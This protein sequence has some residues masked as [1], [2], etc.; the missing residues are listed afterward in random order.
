MEVIVVNKKYKSTIFSYIGEL[1][2]LG[3]FFFDLLS[4]RLPIT[5]INWIIF[6]IGSTIILSGML[7]SIIIIY[8][9]SHNQN[10]HQ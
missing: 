10:N 2:I 6:I 7:I 8:K 5:S 4:R 9:K 3:Y 1:I